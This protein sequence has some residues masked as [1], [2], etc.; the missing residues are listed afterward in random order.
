MDSACRLTHYQVTKVLTNPL[1]GSTSRSNEGKEV[2]RFILNHSDL[3]LLNT[4]DATHFNLS[5]CSESAIDLSFCSASI[6]PDIKWHVTDDLCFSDHFP[7]LLTHDHPIPNVSASPSTQSI[8]NYAKADWIKFRSKIDF[9]FID[10]YLDTSIQPNIDEILSAINANIIDAAKESIPLKKIP[11]NKLPV[12]WWDDEVKQVIKS[13]RK[14]LRK[15]RRVPT[16]DNK[17]EFKKARALARKTIKEKRSSSWNQFVASIDHSTTSGEMFHKMNKLRGKYTPR[18]ITALQD[19]S[20]PTQIFYDTP[21]IASSLAQQ[22]SSVSSNEN[23]SAQFLNYKLSYEAT[24]IDFDFS[25]TQDYNS[26]LTY[27]E[28]SNALATCTSKAAGP[29]DISFIHLKNLPVEA[30]RKL[31]AFY[32]LLWRFGLYPKCWGEALIFPLL[33][34]GKNRLLPSSYRPISLL[35]CSGKL[36][37]KMIN[38]RLFWTLEKKSLL[39]PF[40]S[41]GRLR[42]STVDNLAILENEVAKGFAQKEHTIAAFLDIQKAFDVTWRRK[43]ITTLRK[44]G[45]NGFMLK[46][47]FNF[48][49]NRKIS[50]KCNG[51]LSDKFPLE[52]GIAQGSSLSP[53]LFIVSLNDIFEIIKPPLKRTLFIDD[54]LIIARG[55]N[56]D[57]LLERFQ[58]TLT[59]IHK[60]SE[61]NGVTFS[62]D[63]G[64]SVCIDFH[65]LRKTTSPSLTYNGIQLKFVSGTKFLG[66]QWDSKM[67]WSLHIEYIKKRA[68]NSLNALKMICNKR[69]GVR[70]E[71]LLKFYKSFILPIFDYGSFIYGSA[72]DHL[73]SKLNTIHHTGIRIATGALRSSPVVSLYVDSGIPPLSLRRAKLLMNYV[74]KVRASPFNPV[75]KVLFDQDLSPYNFTTNKPKPLLSRFQSLPNFPNLISSSDMAPYVRTVPPWSSSSPPVDLSLG[76]DRKKDTPPV[77]FQQLFAGVINS[78]YENYKICYTDGSK[79][80]NTTSC[81]YSIDDVISSSQ[82]NPVNSIFSAELIAIYLCL[83]AIIVH[84]SDRFLIVS[85]SRSALA[86]LSNVSFTNPLVSKVYYCW[87]LLKT[88]N[89]DVHFLWCPSHCGIRGNEAVDEAACNPVNPT[90]LKLCSP[91]DFKP[92][93]ASIISKEW[94]IQWDNV[95]NTNKLKSIKP[96]IVHW[97]TSNQDNRTQ[98][99]VLTRMRIGHTRITHSFLFT[100][101]DPPTCECGAHLSVRH[102]LTCNRHDQIRSSLPHPPSLTDS[103]EGVKSLFKYLQDINIYHLI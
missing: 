46:Y 102:I 93:A 38:K 85:D 18:H 25:F 41:G 101:T 81:A 63:P 35:N 71:V 26:P 24:P 86:A 44:F 82:L 16:I 17:I 50:V 77:V 27:A 33:K 1:W 48:L 34:P 43:I 99:I 42:R 12:P 29:D 49:Y 10:T 28:M 11:A 58:H 51:Q 13:R 40:Q 78:K 65:R 31:L 90:R 55:K 84:P 96:L 64:K 79:T 97:N 54:L 80:M 56:M 74:A 75:H 45:I 68:L 8:W 5:Y 9:S 103:D 66:L 67:N 57:S 37:E 98:E 36:L 100:K 19:P 76:K 20:D 83:E 15:A 3:S 52:N 53:L 69:W 4:G 21:S 32:N 7:I 88:R 73:L 61:V 59:D 60:W 23:Y 89:K 72:K 87:N 14:W 95:P 92:V 47:L 39:N 70:R 30:L 91:E 94:Q 6:Y 62:T 22:F 2:E